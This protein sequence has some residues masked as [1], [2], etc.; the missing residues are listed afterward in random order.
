[1]KKNTHRCLGSGF[2]FSV[3]AVLAKRDRV[4]IPGKPWTFLYVLW[5]EEVKLFRLEIEILARKVEIIKKN[6]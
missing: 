2:W 1:M 5:K 3:L 6:F 4:Y